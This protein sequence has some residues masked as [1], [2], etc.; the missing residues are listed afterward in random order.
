MGVSWGLWTP[1]TDSR[2]SQAVRRSSCLAGV[3]VSAPGAPGLRVTHLPLDWRALPPPLHTGPPVRRGGRG[4]IVFFG[5]RE[6]RFSIVSLASVTLGSD[7]SGEALSGR[8]M[9]SEQ[10]AVPL[11]SEPGDKAAASLCS[12]L[13]S[14]GLHCTS[15]GK[16][17]RALVPQGPWRARPRPGSSSRFGADAPISPDLL[18]PRCSLRSALSTS[19]RRPTRP[20][21]P[22]YPSQPE[23]IFLCSGQYPSV[24][25]RPR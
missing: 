2:P 10:E 18:S 25:E 17:G 14:R 8:R 4:D 11:G 23:S 12:P 6:W 5:S 7:K 24:A 13:P 9:L 19:S 21:A 16:P 1:S 22:P 3:P 15:P 20:T